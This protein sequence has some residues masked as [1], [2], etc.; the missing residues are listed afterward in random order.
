M[1]E[2]LAKHRDAL[3][4]IV[5]L[6]P[7]LSRIRLGL[8]AYDSP[9]LNRYADTLADSHTSLRRACEQLSTAAIEF[10]VSAANE[11][12]ALNAKLADL[13]AEVRVAHRNVRNHQ[14]RFQELQNS[15]QGQREDVDRLQQRCNS[16]KDA[17]LAADENI[18]EQKQ[19]I[20]DLKRS[21]SLERHK[22]DLHLH[23]P[24][25][26]SL[27]PTG[28]PSTDSGFSEVALASSPGQ[29]THQRLAHDLFEDG[30][31][32]YTS[33]NFCAAQGRFKSA[34]DIINSLP[35]R[36]SQPVDVM[37]LAYYRTVCEA[38]TVGSQEG[39]LALVNFLRAHNQVPARQLAHVR[40]LLARNSV[41]L[42]QLDDAKDH[43]LAAVGVR[44]QLDAASDE[45][46]DSLALLARIYTLLDSDTLAATL[47]AHCPDSQRET[48]RSR[49]AH[50]RA[51]RTSSLQTG[52]GTQAAPGTQ[53]TR[54]PTTLKPTAPSV[55]RRVT[56]PRLPT[57]PAL[58]TVANA[59]SS[60][61]SRRRRQAQAAEQLPW[62]FRYSLRLNKYSLPE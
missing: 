5:A 31:R 57:N 19:T 38:E 44:H 23:V 35:R 13:Q 10:G 48:V 42:N 15:L 43:C 24:V 53:P 62:I 37:Q 59:T 7:T 39:K 61:S 17:L 20:D 8:D 11:Q 22:R 30:V 16:Y 54:P 52:T 45:Y 34:Q 3:K 18:Q 47:I 12:A 41:K 26:P 32:E 1:D 56:P 40:H 55:T 49:Y 33:G 27:S 25:S 28:R 9:T 29:E 6:D 14:Q 58:S 46:F 36:L 2:A 21:L 60:A 4:T 51:D 50:L